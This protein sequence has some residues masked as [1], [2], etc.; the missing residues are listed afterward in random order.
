VEELIELR[1]KYPKAELPPLL[2][3]QF[4]KPPSSPKE[5]I[6]AL[7]TETISADL[8]TKIT[9]C[10]FGGDPDC[11]QCGCF[12]SMALAAVG[13]VKLS[14]VIPVGG[15]FFASDRIGKFVASRRRKPEPV[16]AHPVVP[17]EQLVTLKTKTE[18]VPEPTSKR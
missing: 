14:G 1:V 7:T 15:L 5:C 13:D 6:F 8:K 9:P 16:T 3:K 17:S 18:S 2:L 4:L 12:A 10:Q 11:S